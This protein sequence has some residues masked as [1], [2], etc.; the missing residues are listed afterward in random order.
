MS[1][2]GKDWPE[3]VF[4]SILYIAKIIIMKNIAKIFF[5]TTSGK[6]ISA[7]H[8]FKSQHDIN[9]TNIK[10]ILLPKTKVLV[11]YTINLDNVRSYMEL[12]INII[13][14]KPIGE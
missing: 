7:M 14:V 6:E 10:D 2:Y 4:V 9:V 11:V 12:N 13:D 8:F 1:P 3:P 5:V